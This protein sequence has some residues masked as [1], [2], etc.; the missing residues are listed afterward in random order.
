MEEREIMKRTVLIIMIITIVSKLFGLLRDV[1]LSYYYGTSFISDA[2]II[3]T[4]IPSVIF[5]FVLVG[6]LAGFIPMYNQVEKEDGLAAADIFTNNV[7][8]ILLIICTDRKSVV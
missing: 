3:S 1:V 7:L 2:Y 4:T 8:N 6:L 5:G